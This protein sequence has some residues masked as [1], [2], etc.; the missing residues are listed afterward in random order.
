MARSS[1]REK[2]LTEGLR[3][4]R[5]R[6][7]ASASV[8]DIVQAA[9]VPQGSFTNHF[10]SKE[11]FGL[12]VIDLY[13]HGIRTFNDE[14][15]NNAGLPPDRR[16]R[17]WVAGAAGGSCNGCL[18]GNF[19]A[20]GCEQSEPIRQRVASA[21]AET[22]TA[23]AACLH[24]AGQAGMLRPGLDHDD[25]AGFLLAS[26]QGASLLAR[27]TQDP[28]PL[29]GIDRLLLATILTSPAPANDHLLH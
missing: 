2:I 16:L 14:T 5:Q 15:L 12:E 10:A 3:L 7:F 18:L 23:L 17:N 28:A 9:G 1:N 8:R 21:F 24:A 29:R 11:A 13:C 26:I 4:M 20:G 19:A 27:V 6:G 25:V 22:R